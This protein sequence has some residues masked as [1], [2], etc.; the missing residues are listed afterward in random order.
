MN[1][2][3]NFYHYAP[4]EFVQTVLFVSLN[5]DHEYH[6]GTDVK[7]FTSALTDFNIIDLLRGPFL[8]MCPLI[9]IEIP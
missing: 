6:D 4:E 7:F 3:L 2:V 5:I 1:L 8:K 9:Y